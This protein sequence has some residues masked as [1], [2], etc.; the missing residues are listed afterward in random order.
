M[1]DSSFIWVIIGR[2]PIGMEPLTKILL[3][4]EPLTLLFG[5]TFL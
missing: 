4:L 3:L 2:L 5:A 1:F